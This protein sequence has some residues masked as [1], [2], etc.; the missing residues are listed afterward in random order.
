MP[1]TPLSSALRAIAVCEYGSMSLART[2]AAPAI[3]AATA[4]SPLPAPR[5]STRR[6]ATVSGWS[7]TYRAS[8]WPPGQANAQNGGGWSLA[9]PPPVRSQSPA[10]SAAWCSRSSG[11][12]GT[13]ISVVATESDIGPDSSGA[14]ILT[15]MR[16]VIA[17]GHGQIAT[18]LER[19][20]AGRGDAAV[21][22]IRNPGQADDLRAAGAEPVVLDLER[23]S[24]DEVAAALDGADAAVFAAGAGPGSGAARKDTVDR[25][26]A[27]LFADAAER[28]GV[29]RYLQ[30]SAMGLE[31]ADDPCVDPV[32]A[33]YLRAKAA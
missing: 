16:V 5:S 2:A 9:Y 19:L 28:A 3:S 31:R 8:A 24:V 1:A 14:T 33:T 23:A 11:T 27:V 32:F 12:A 26:A 7:S 18:A 29:R 21:G 15:A 22:L 10:A 6:P 25:G 17:G 30:V 13:G 4:T 20:L